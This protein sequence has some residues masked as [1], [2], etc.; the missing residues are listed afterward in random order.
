MGCIIIPIV[1]RTSIT[2]AY[3]IPFVLLLVAVLFFVAGSKRYVNV[4]PGHEM[5][6]SGRSEEEPSN[7]DAPKPNFADV[8]R[9]CALIVPFNI[10][11]SQCPTTCE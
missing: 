4:V 1:A 9:I 3:T 5:E 11:Y 6:S 7:T 8:A 2:A 10:A